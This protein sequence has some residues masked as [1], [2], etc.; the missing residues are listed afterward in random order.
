M[1]ITQFL[2]V[3]G[4]LA[5]VNPVFGSRLDG[6]PL[7]CD[8]FMISIATKADID[9]YSEC[10]ELPELDAFFGLHHNFTGPFEMPN[11]KSVT[12]FSAGYLGPKSK[13]SDRVDDGVTS[14]SMPDLEEVNGGWMLVAYLNELTSISFPKLHTVAVDLV[15]VDNPKLRK[16]T[17]PA[18]VNVTSGMLVDGHFDE[19]NLP[20]LKHVA[21][22]KVK[23]TGAVD[24]Q[25]LG[26]NLSSLVFH[27]D[28]NDVGKGF[29]CWTPD[30]KNRYNSSDPNPTSSNLSE[31]ASVRAGYLTTL[32][33]LVAMATFE[34]LLM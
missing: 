13:G 32:F 11:V 17:L 1:C 18:L 19:I 20:K 22:L 9:F 7:E 24:C 29:T 5:S 34:K 25:A 12:R 3:A 23:S 15:V 26:K 27:P 14:I 2:L 4:F 16:L 10:P 8:D 6:E 30:E 21:F 33:G 28:K 31:G